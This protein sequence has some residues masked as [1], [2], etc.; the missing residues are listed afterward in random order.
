MKKVLVT[1]AAGFIGFHLSKALLEQSYDVVGIDNINDYYCRTL[2]KSRLGILK[3]YKKFTFYKNDIC[4]EKELKNIFKTNSFDVVI[5]L[6]AQAGV[7][8]SLENPREYI[9]SNIIGF[10]NVLSLSVENEVKHVLYASSSS[11]YGK[12]E[13]LPFSEADKTDHPLSLYAATKKSNE[14]IAHAYSNVYGIPTTGLRFFTVYGPWG[15][16]DMA[17]YKFTEKIINNKPIE[18]FNNGDH[19]RDFTYVD[20]I[21]NGIIPL[22]DK[23]LNLVDTKQKG[24]ANDIPWRVLNIGNGDPRPL[25]D[26]INEIEKNL[27]L[28]SM[29]ELLPL[30]KGDVVAT[31]ADISSLKSLT[32]YTPKT[33]IEKGVKNFIEWYKDYYGQ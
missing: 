30:Q 5:N 14:E 22:I 1:G 23:P 16:P 29:K 6:A 18:V 10:F 11:V 31:S 3:K 25:K 24:T 21:I 13:K 9:Q 27:G 33:K 19:V 15:R 26:Y 2:K 8:Y 12:N 17:L 20:D 7:R 28:E 32:G 4:K